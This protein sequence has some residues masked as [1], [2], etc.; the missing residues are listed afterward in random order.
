MSDSP[1]L[2]IQKPVAVWQRPIEVK[3][4]KLAQSLGK[5]AIAGAF[6]HWAGVASTGVTVWEALGLK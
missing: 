6:G 4:G 1:G 2:P 3:F 5:G